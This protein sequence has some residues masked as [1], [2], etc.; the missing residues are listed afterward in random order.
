MAPEAAILRARAF[1]SKGLCGKALRGLESL[2]ALVKKKVPSPE[3][4]IFRADCAEMNMEYDEAARFLQEIWFHHSG[5]PQ[6]D[7]AQARL[8][9]LQARGVSL[10]EASLD[11]RRKRA[12][13]LLG[14][15]RYRDAQ[16]EFSML[17][18][19]APQE[20]G[21]A[22]RILEGEALVRLREYDQ[23][24]ELFEAVAVE[25]EDPQ[26]VREALFW[27]GRVAARRSQLEALYDVEH[28]LAENHPRSAQ[29]ARVIYYIADILEDRGDKDGARQAF[30]SILVDFPSGR[31][32]EDTAWRLGWLAY[33]DGEFDEAIWRFGHFV[34]RNPSDP[35]SAQYLYWI[36]RSAEKAGR[37]DEALRAFSRACSLKL[38]SYYCQRSSVRFARLPIFSFMPASLSPENR[39]SEP[40]LSRISLSFSLASQRIN[41]FS[42]YPEES[43]PSVVSHPAFFVVSELIA[44]RMLPEARKELA[45]LGRHKRWDS[46]SILFL[47]DLFDRIGDPYQSLRLV[48]LY[49]N[50]L[51]ANGGSG[52]PERF[53][54]LAF[55]SAQVLDT[56]EHYPVEGIDPYLASAVA[57][58][59]SAYNAAVVS[60]A[61]AIG[62]MQLM[63]YTAREVARDLGLGDVQAE[64]LKDPVLNIRLGSR[65]LRDLI[66]RFEG[67]WV[68]A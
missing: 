19:I 38:R 52:V 22:L 21:H 3:I 30:E 35:E 36:G 58:E 48:R 15:G 46:E 68:L 13:W 47:S 56:F 25:S 55:P 20:E 26:E 16:V 23:A 49:Y 41:G 53:W 8:E 40:S 44:M 6:A 11:D 31:V 24:V 50:D 67:N 4:L 33:M 32:A 9:D 62:L 51:I 37:A 17:A 39:F 42:L 29:R 54:R 27:L 45:Q 5:S 12:E 18:G 34:D 59:E 28:R 61:G 63:P 7:I 65:Y 10:P 66:D 60:R 43:E 14:A 1:I 64:D 2:P 57:R